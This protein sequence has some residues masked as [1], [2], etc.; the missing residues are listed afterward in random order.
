MKTKILQPI[1]NMLLTTIISLAAFQITLAQDNVSIYATDFIGPVGLSVDGSGNLYVNE[2]GTGNN[3][4][5]ITLLTPTGERHT[6]I[7]GLP[8]EFSEESGE[9]LGAW[10]SIL[11]P[12]G[13]AFVLQGEGLGN[14]ELAESILTFDITGYVAGGTPL[15][16]ADVESVFNIGD[17]TIAQGA[18]NSN[19]YSFVIA[20]NGDMFIVDAGGNSVLH[21]NAMTDE[22]SVFA[23]FDPIPNPLPFGPPVSD[24]V[25]T[26]I[27]PKPDGSGFYVCHLRGFPF[28]PGTANVY[29]VDMA[30]DLSIWQSG[31]TS[32]VDMAIDPRDGNLVVLEFSEFS[33]DTTP[34]NFLPAT[35]RAIKLH[36]DGSR[37]IMAEGLNF[38]AG[39]AF[40]ADGNLYISSI[41]T[42][43]I[44]KVAAPAPKI[45][46]V[47]AVGF[48]GPVGIVADGSGNLW[49]NE[50]GTGSNDGKLVALTPNFQKHDVISGLPSEFNAENGETVGAWRT[51]FTNDGKVIVVQGEGLGS[52]N[53]SE[54]L[55]TFDISGYTIGDMAMTT[56]DLEATYNIGDYSIAQ[57]AINSNPYSMAMDAVGNMFVVDAG[58]NTIVR[59]DAATG[60]LSIFA[61]FAP[62]PNPLPFGPPVSDAVPTKILAKPDGSGFYVCH[63]RGFPFLP[64]TA[65][66]Y[67]VDMSGNVSVFQSGF[68]SLTDMAFDPT[69]GN[70][71]VLEFS[72]FSLET[73]PPNFTPETGRAIKIHADGSREIIAEGMNFTAGMGYA[74]N[75]DLYITSI[76]T[77][78]IYK[79]PAAQAVEIVIAH[80]RICDV[81]SQGQSQVTGIVTGGVAPYQVSGNFNGEVGENAPF[82]FILDDNDN[83]YQITVVDALGNEN[84][85]IVTGLIPCTKLPIE[86][87]SFEG[88]VKMEGNLLQWATASETNNDFFTLSYSADGQNFV[89]LQQI[90]GNG[91]TFDVHR[92]EF[93]H[94]NAPKGTVY[95]QLS[96]T[97]LDGTTKIL[98]VVSLQRG[99]SSIAAIEVYP[100]ATNAYLN[101][102]FGFA[103]ASTEIIVS[104]YDVSGRV[105]KS[106]TLDK[107]VTQLQLDVSNLLSGTY[108]LKMNNSFEV[109]TAKFIKL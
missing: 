90:A 58:G 34:P 75:G 59:R 37:E 50:V 91:S 57:G 62:I 29:E 43:V 6:M 42:G 20:P 109:L 31:F 73:T 12:D 19:P 104:M 95:Y 28:L 18:T 32:L 74:P 55:L 86:F 79:V 17:F 5:K 40:D 64:G 52:S 30:G 98:G 96:Q 49:V 76:F 100:T 53:L 36:T 89:P 10:R 48:N 11:T 25:P 7:G 101:V 56:A 47:Y 33:L 68:T 102:S 38:T 108:I 66:V 84:E 60:Q 77:G 78:V 106:Q 92:Y 83:S 70:L 93:L 97:D 21:R 61:T 44:Y 67:E 85:V 63:L 72:A 94:R 14:N 9:T 88:E 81:P 15:G 87:L 69:D 3:D 16:I 45:P 71:V 107:G 80:Q 54:S 99:E 103:N 46:D 4:G 35:G 22:L 39:M 105:V 8:S 13:K 26:K 41:F 23:T 27:L 24:A 2:V 82:I 51:V 65:N 1:F